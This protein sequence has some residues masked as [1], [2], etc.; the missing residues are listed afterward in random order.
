[1]RRSA[2]DKVTKRRNKNVIL[3]VE[4]N[5]KTLRYAQ[6]DMYRG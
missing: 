1:M 2:C 3:N 4:K 5:L 6:N